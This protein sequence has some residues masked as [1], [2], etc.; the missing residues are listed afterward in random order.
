MFEN[1][2]VKEAIRLAMADKARLLDMREEKSYQDGHLPTAIWVTE[3]K[4]RD[5]LSKNPGIKQILYCDFGNQSMRLARDLDQEGFQVASIV[6][7]Y[8]AYEGYIEKK[9]DKIWTME[10]KNNSHF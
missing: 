10:W 4:V 5:Y 8:R 1:I 9:R 2:S 3:A 6:G 7:G